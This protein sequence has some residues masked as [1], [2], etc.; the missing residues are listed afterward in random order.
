MSA[1]VVLEA[2]WTDLDALAPRLDDLVRHLSRAELAHADR[3]RATRDRDRYIARNGWLREQLATRLCRPAGKIAFAHNAY[4]KP[5]LIGAAIGFSL[6]QSDGVA[7][8]ACGPTAAIGCDIEWRSSHFD[9]TATAERFFS[10]AERAALASLPPAHR[11]AGFYNA[12]TRKE[13]YAKALGCGLSLPLDAFDVELDPRRPARL[14]RGCKGWSVASFAPFPG[15]QA[16][17]VAAGDWR[18][19]C[20]YAGAGALSRQEA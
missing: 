15:F 17:V 3:F 20:E 10:R 7:L 11:L 8:L 6:S 16:A 13:A 18:L 19:R 9:L 5:F 14:L 12:W 4:G 1:C 2:S